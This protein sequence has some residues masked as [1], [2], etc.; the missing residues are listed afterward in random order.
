MTER[1]HDT[2]SQ[3]SVRTRMQIFLLLWY[4]S[5]VGRE[6][7]LRAGED[8]QLLHAVLSRLT[9]R[10]WFMLALPSVYEA[11]AGAAMSGNMTFQPV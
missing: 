5:D 9:Q 1:L 8:W 7:A 3:T 4:R 2:H 6:V 10:V 11:A